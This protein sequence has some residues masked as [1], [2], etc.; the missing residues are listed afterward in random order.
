MCNFDNFDQHHG[1][2]WDI[3]LSF[4]L[5]Y[6]DTHPRQEKVKLCYFNEPAVAGAVEEECIT[7]FFQITFQL[8]EQL[9]SY[10]E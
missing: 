10:E 9:L 4:L 6:F 7:S 5:N 2:K 1:V 8:E 3:F